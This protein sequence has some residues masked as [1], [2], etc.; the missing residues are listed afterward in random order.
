MLC[1]LYFKWRADALFY[2]S[3]FVSKEICCSSILHAQTIIDIDTNNFGKQHFFFLLPLITDI[4]GHNLFDKFHT[5]QGKEQ[6]R[7]EQKRIK[8]NEKRKA[9]QNGETRWKTK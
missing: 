1:E 5:S 4:Y 7:T 6:N 3:P 8:T 2:F 9:K